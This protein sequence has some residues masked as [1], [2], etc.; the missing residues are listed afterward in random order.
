MLV[1]VRRTNNMLKSYD[2]ANFIKVSSTTHRARTPWCSSFCLCPRFLPS[3]FPLADRS[4]CFSKLR[5]SSN[6]P[7]TAFTTLAGATFLRSRPRRR[8]PAGPFLRPQRRCFSLLAFGSAPVRSGGAGVGA[9][10]RLAPPPPSLARRPK[11]AAPRRKQYAQLRT[12]NNSLHPDMH[13][14]VE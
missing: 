9:G 8:R 10:R 7:A 2:V 11:T 13:N 4:A 5:A 14:P 12:V 3:R 6:S 1:P